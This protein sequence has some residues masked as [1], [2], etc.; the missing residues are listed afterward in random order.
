MTIYVAFEPKI[1]NVWGTAI[2]EQNM[3]VEEAKKMIAETKARAEAAGSKAI[4][5]TAD[6]LLG[7]FLADIEAAWRRWPKMTP[8]PFRTKFGGDVPEW[9]QFQIV[10][11]IFPGGFLGADFAATQGEADAMIEAIRADGRHRAI[12][13]EKREVA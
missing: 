12:W 3:T 4:F 2:C 5:Q 11:K 1:G 8:Y 10:T 6:E 13:V 7:N 9:A